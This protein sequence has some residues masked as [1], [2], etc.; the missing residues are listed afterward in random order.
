MGY[1]A[2]A[3]LGKWHSFCFFFIL[4]SL[5]FIYR[6]LVAC[7]PKRCCCYQPTETLSMTTLQRVLGFFEL[8]MMILLPPNASARTIEGGQQNGPETVFFLFIN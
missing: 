5:P 8:T 2:F 3:V 1:L 4:L 6:V 7:F